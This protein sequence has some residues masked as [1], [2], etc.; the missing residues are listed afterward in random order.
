[1]NQFNSRCEQNPVYSGHESEKFSVYFRKSF[2][3][4]GRKLYV[5]QLNSSQIGLILAQFDQSYKGMSFREENTQTFD[6]IFYR[7]QRMILDTQ[8]IK[9]SV[10]VKY[11]GSL[12]MNQLT[13]T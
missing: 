13:F 12:I 3:F 10:S 9:L 6:F 8:F 7:F 4:Y 2:D 1:M 5:L 11:V